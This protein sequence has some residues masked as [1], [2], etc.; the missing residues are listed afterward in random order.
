MI[1][2]FMRHLKEGDV[3]HGIRFLTEDL[4]E[5]NEYLEVFD[6][7]RKKKVFKAVIRID[8]THHKM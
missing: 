7:V 8:Q 4:P 2:V 5:A 3:D 6:K 1:T